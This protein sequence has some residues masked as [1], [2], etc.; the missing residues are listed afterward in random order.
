[1]TANVSVIRTLGAFVLAV[2]T[3]TVAT[4]HGPPGGRLERNGRLRTAL[5]TGRGERLA[6]AAIAVAA[7]TS[8][9]AAITA[10]ATTTSAAT[11]GFA[12]LTTVATTLG[13]VGETTFRIALLVGCAVDEVRTAIRT[14]NGF[15]Y[16]RHFL[17]LPFN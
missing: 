2:V 6:R 8:A 14:Y 5:G 9:M 17:L 13:F 16:V 4:V 11:L 7:A 10:T 15:V 12:L 3:E 1:M